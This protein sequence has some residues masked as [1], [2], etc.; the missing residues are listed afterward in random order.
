MPA[1]FPQQAVCGRFFFS[2]QSYSQWQYSNLLHS[3]QPEGANM[4]LPVGQQGSSV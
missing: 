1:A 3:V 4:H 2:Q